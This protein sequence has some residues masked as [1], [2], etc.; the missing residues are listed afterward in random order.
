M[1][2]LEICVNSLGSVGIL[3]LKVFRSWQD[4]DCLLESLCIVSRNWWVSGQLKV[5][6]CNQVR[7]FHMCVPVRANEACARWALHI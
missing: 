1:N 4:S 2:S 6:N 5:S 7:T 3:V